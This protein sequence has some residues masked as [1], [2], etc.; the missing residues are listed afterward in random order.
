MRKL[1]YARP[2]PS[3]EPTSTGLAPQG[4]LSIIRLAAPILRRAP[5]YNVRCSR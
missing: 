4:V 2:N 3:H 1:H 5:S